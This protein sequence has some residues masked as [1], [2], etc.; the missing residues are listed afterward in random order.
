MIRRAGRGLLRAQGKEKDRD[1]AAAVAASWR[2]GRQRNVPSPQTPHGAVLAAGEEGGA[3]GRSGR[4]TAGAAP[5]MPSSAKRRQMPFAAAAVT[6]SGRRPENLRRRA[7][8]ARGGVRGGGGLRGLV[9]G[10]GP[11]AGR[12]PA[13]ERGRRE[14]RWGMSV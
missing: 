3:A 6:G 7:A 1:K 14:M 12:L 5:G 13:V 4:R 2:P 11:R 8:G 9:K 10:P